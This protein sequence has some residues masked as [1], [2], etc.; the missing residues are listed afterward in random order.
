MTRESFDITTHNKGKESEN[1]YW[2]LKSSWGTGTRTHTWK[3]NQNIL[4]DT[5][6]L[7]NEK[8]ANLCEHTTR[9]ASLEFLKGAT[10]GLWE[11]WVEGNLKGEST[12]V[13][14]FPR[15]LYIYT[16]TEIGINRGNSYWKNE[17]VSRWQAQINQKSTS[18]WHTSTLTEV[19]V[20]QKRINVKMPHYSLYCVHPLLINKDF[21]EYRN[22]LITHVFFYV[23]LSFRDLFIFSI[24][25]CS[26][27]FCAN[28]SVFR[29]KLLLRYSNYKIY[30]KMFKKG[31][32]AT[33]TWLTS[34][35]I[36]G[37]DKAQWKVEV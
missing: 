18:K 29:N 14:S 8:R 3:Q 1:S 20:N 33:P 11:E 32:S 2:K 17:E 34:L 10:R 25:H 23:C 9:V 37:A 26:P 19:F 13:L 24:I 22:I 35:D 31:M 28:K 15:G 6:V 12:L 36:S 30:K 16:H 27:Y 21:H 4:T 7:L 5:A